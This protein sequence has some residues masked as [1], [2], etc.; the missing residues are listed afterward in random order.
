MTIF[1]YALVPLIAMPCAL[2]LIQGAVKLHRQHNSNLRAECIRDIMP[3]LCQSHTLHD[4]DIERLHRRFTCATLRDAILFIADN[5]YGDEIYRL[6]S[7]IEMCGIDYYLIR[8]I[9][10]H[11]GTKRA[12]ALRTLSHLPLTPSVF[13]IAEGYIDKERHI[14]FYAA[15]TIIASRPERAIRYITRSGSISRTATTTRH[16]SIH[17]IAKLRK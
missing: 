10:R 12:L 4:N 3:L 15:A 8:N 13:E 5:I 14:S 7:I 9:Q 11:S 6:T 2:L 17:P 16:Y 1:I